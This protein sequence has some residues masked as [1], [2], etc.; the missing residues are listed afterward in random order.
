MPLETSALLEPIP[1]ENPGGEYLRYDPIY[2]QIRQA[3]VEEEDLPAGEW[4][5]ER[6]TADFALVIRLA[7]EV[8]ATRSKD[9][10]IAAWL[11]EALLRREGFRGLTVGLDV[12]RGLIE[13]F[14]DHLHPELEDDDAEMRAAPLVWVGE[15]LDRAIRMAPVVLE[16][17]DMAD[18]RDSRAVGYEEDATTYEKRDQRNAA[19]AAGKMTA[20]EFDAAFAD[21]SKAWYREQI[22]GI[23][24]AVAAAGALGSVCDEKFG[25]DAPNYAPLIGALKEVR[26]V[27][28]QLLS[29]KLEKDPDPIEVVTEAVVADPA[30][31]GDAAATGAGP[32][33]SVPGIFAG[34]SVGTPAA[35]PP[36]TGRAGAEANI[37]AA[38][39][40]L[41]REAPADPAP[42]LLLRG[43]RW[44]ELR[45]GGGHVEPTLLTAPP[46]EVRS[47]VKGLLLDE[48]WEDLLEAAE[49]VMASPFGRGWLD[50]QR[51][52]IAAVDALGEEFAP[53]GRAVRGALR[54]L[55]EDLPELPAMTLADDTPVANGETIAWLKAEGLLPD[56]VRSDDSFAPPP[57]PRRARFDPVVRAR[58][59]ARGGQTS[60]AVDLLMRE[61]SQERS[62]RGRFLRRVQAASILVEADLP[63]VALPILEE[64]SET[65]SEHN[66]ETWEDPT[67][68]AE[69]LGLLYRCH[70]AIDGNASSVYNLFERI[71][72]LDPLQAIR[73]QPPQEG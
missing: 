51:Y 70:V 57:P 49:E 35:A 19:I 47:R 13:N 4:E 10:Q 26:Q 16:G 2:D 66:L 27:L 48:K 34:P 56:G 36:P 12:I 52:V 7:Q 25:R 24:A 54:A 67:L 6:K 64:I 50:L 11:T 69:P 39:R 17:Y 8:L 37:A 21:T 23:D 33:V 22:A 65:I 62:P 15:Y 71:C 14:W 32:G 63:T 5:R 61:A 68:V 53:V 46:T 45:A 41:R 55:L 20:E 58:E 18:Y 42:Y 59:L 38:A 9:L 30:E 73:V 31:T 60:D 43:F 72:R 44:G 1:G 3:R 28:D 40:F 29:L